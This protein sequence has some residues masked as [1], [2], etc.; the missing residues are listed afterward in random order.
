[1]QYLSRKLKYLTNLDAPTTFI[2]YVKVSVDLVGFLAGKLQCLISRD[3][4]WTYKEPE[5][6]A[7]V[8]G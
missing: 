8:G 6:P 7:I 3:C 5:T 4:C 1:M 2:N